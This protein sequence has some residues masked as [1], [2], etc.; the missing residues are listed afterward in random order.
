MCEKNNMD[1]W[2]AGGA[3]SGRLYLSTNINASFLS[4]HFPSQPG[5]AMRLISVQW[6]VNTSGPI[7]GSLV[8]CPLE[9]SL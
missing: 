8:L 6:E 2:V 4:S 5:M 1:I 9:Q 7:L 3:N